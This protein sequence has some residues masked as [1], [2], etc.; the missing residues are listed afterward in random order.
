MIIRATA[1]GIGIDGMQSHWAYALGK[2]WM[3][4][5]LGPTAASAIVYPGAEHQMLAVPQR[6]PGQCFGCGNHGYYRPR[7]KAS[8][9][10]AMSQRI[11]RSWRLD[12]S[13]GCRNLRGGEHRYDCWDDVTAAAVVRR[14]HELLDRITLSPTG[15]SAHVSLLRGGNGDNARHR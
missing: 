12:L 11:G 9:E 5:L 8:L 15:E 6:M 1:A 2:P 3:V 14:F 7:I 13:R 10:R 4:L